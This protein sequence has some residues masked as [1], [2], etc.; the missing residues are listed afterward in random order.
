MMYVII[1]DSHIAELYAEE[2]QKGMG[3]DPSKISLLVISPG[4]ESKSFKT[5]ETLTLELKRLGCGRDVT[6]IALGGGVI[7][8]LTGFLA[9]TY[10]RGVKWIAIPTTLLAMID[11]SIGGKTGINIEGAKNWI[12]SHYFASQLII[13]PYFLKTL[14]PEEW[15]NGIVEMLK[16]FLLTCEETFLQFSQ[17]PFPSLIAKAIE[18][19]RRIVAKDPHE[20]GERALLNLGHTIG[21]ALEGLSLYSMS[22]GKTVGV[23]IVLESRLSYFM[24][25]LSKRDLLV[26]E[27]SFPS[28]HI[29]YSFEE[30]YSQL[31][32]DKKN[33]QGVPHFVLLQG[34]GVPYV[35]EGNY[36][37]P[38]PE[39]ILKK[40]L[41]D[42]CMRPC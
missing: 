30:L 42:A 15:E 1:C 27:K 14:P 2:I 3:F 39:E 4:E 33:K 12:G 24:G 40:V 25:L 29:S 37:H 8:D 5:F 11:A 38:V 31:R 21:H 28:P 22:H 36:A 17:V 19:K 23:G 10:C 9:S 7:L 35:H 6:L 26:I 32:L 34:I 41:D 13:N 20:K 16:I 18:A